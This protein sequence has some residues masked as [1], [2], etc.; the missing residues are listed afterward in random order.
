MRLPFVL[1]PA[2]MMPF[3]FERIG[4]KVLAYYFKIVKLQ[5]RWNGWAMK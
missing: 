3:L 1:M 5:S 2:Q 4:F